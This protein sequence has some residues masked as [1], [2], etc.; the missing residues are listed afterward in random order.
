MD[1]LDVLDESY[2][3]EIVHRCSSQLGQ[4]SLRFLEVL[5]VFSIVHMVNT[6]KSVHREDN[7]RD[8]ILSKNTTRVLLPTFEAALAGEI[9]YGTNMSV[10]R[11]PWGT[12]V[13]WCGTRYRVK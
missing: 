1:L 11:V 8:E 9:S 4:Q 10:P 2:Q 13:L 6:S 12:T 3:L 7:V 5:Y